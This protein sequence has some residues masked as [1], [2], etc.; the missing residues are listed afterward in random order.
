MQIVKPRY[1]GCLG[2]ACYTIGV[3]IRT[4]VLWALFNFLVLVI[5]GLDQSQGLGLVIS[6]S[7]AS[8]W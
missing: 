2:R 8:F 4:L 3:S 6:T 5:I 1:W 7:M